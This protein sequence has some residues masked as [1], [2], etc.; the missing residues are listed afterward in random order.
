MWRHFLRRRIS[1]Y[2]PFTHRAYERVICGAQSR[3]SPLPYSTL[4]WAIDG[5]VDVLIP[6]I[7]W[8]SQWQHATTSYG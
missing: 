4:L 5:E 3:L 1:G 2:I 6:M 7:E 8:K